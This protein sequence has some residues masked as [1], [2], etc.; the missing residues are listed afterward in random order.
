MMTSPSD[1]KQAEEKVN[2]AVCHLIGKF[3]QDKVAIQLTI[4][5]SCTIHFMFAH[6][7]LIFAAREHVSA[8]RELVFA[9]RGHNFSHRE[10]TFFC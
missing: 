10:K 5:Y 7:E 2:N 8:H 3:L 1:S 4:L 9:A 6:R